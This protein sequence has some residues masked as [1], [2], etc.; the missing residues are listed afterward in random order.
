MLNNLTNKRHINGKSY[1]YGFTTGSCAAAA[2]KAAVTMLLTQKVLDE[3]HITTPANIP[4]TISLFDISINEKEVSCAVTKD[5]GDDPDV[6]NGIKIVAKAWL[7]T[8]KR[9]IITTGIGIG[10]VTKKGLQVPVGQAAINPTPMKMILD[11]VSALLQP[12]QGV[13]VDLSVTDGEAIAKK[14]FNERLGVIGGISILGTSGIVVPMSEEAFKDA[15]SLDI[16]V[17]KE[18]GYCEIVLTPGNYGEAFIATHIPAAKHCT[19]TT[20][21]FIGYMLHE[22]VRFEIKKVLLV[23]HIGKLVKVAGGIF[24]THSSVADARNEILAAHYMH[25]SGDVEGFTQIMQSNTTEEA[26]CYITDITF[27]DYLCEVIKRRCCEHIRNAMDVEVMIF[28]QDKGMLG[29]TMQ[30]NSWI[31]NYFTTK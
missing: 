4:L 11:E 31:Q 15:L 13:T 5:S 19:A 21:N 10:I 14:T 25:Y 16:S 24:H 8:E 26:V 30:A 12:N 22:A 27:F 1:R 18:K 6:T 7:N 17:L 29:K 28:S 2:S 9:L 3:I 23:G 20:S